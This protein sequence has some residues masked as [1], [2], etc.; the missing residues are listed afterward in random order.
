[1]AKIR[2]RVCMCMRIYI[3]IYISVCIHTHTY[4]YIYISVT[5]VLGGLNQQCYLTWA[6]HAPGL[7]GHA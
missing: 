3:H 4:I 1:M 7:D 5:S 2:P 6:S